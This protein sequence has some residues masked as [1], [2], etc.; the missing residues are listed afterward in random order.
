MA[1]LIYGF[2]PLCGWCFGIV[3][4]MQRLRAE[5]PELP[6]APVFPG[7]VTGTRIGPYAEM[8]GYIRQ[9]AVRLRAV[10]G[11]APSEAFY[12][13]IRT[14]GVRGDSGP[15]TAVL[16]AVGESHPDRLMDLAH[17]MT[18]AHFRHGADL[19]RPETHAALFA[20]LG[21][22]RAVPALDDAARI[23]AAWAAGRA[24]GITSFPTLILETAAGRETLPPVYDPAALSAAVAARIGP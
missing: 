9:A 22:D 17:A 10:T 7:L 14:P 20:A 23:A 19:N 2:D 3:P 1:R 5:H 13:L 8:E 11:R 24:E 12:A 16:A 21:I 18:E 15:P 6:I 4:A